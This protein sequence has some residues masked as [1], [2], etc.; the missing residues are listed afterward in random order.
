M[1]DDEVLRQDGEPRRC[2]AQPC[3]DPETPLTA[4]NSVHV[5]LGGGELRMVHEI[6]ADE[7]YER[8]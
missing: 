5:R 3:K 2:D 6:C 4:A 7:R 1:A 8:I